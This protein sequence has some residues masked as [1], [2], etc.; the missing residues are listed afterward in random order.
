MS[1]LAQL[2][3]VMHSNM[4]QSFSK[5]LPEFERNMKETS[6]YDLILDSLTVMRRLFRSDKA[7][8]G[9]SSFHQNFKKISDIILISLNHEYSK[10]VSEGLRVAG[11]FVY[12]LRGSDGATLDSKFDSIVGPLH[13]AILEKLKKT[14]ID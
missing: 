6:N 13:K 9:S 12:I 1:T 14:D 2:A 4:E 11:S 8:Q 7:P 5:I 10:V 3:H